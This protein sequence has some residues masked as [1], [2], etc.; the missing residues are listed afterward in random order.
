[1]RGYND[2]LAY[3][4]ELFA[5]KKSKIL[6]INTEKDDAQEE[7][8]LE[9]HEGAKVGGL[10]LLNTVKNVLC[11]TFVLSMICMLIYS[12]SEI[13]EVKDQ[14]STTETEI[15][16]LISE[17]T[18]LK[19]EFEKSI[20]L[21]NIEE[22]AR[23]LGMKKQESGQTSYLMVS[24]KD[25]VEVLVSEDESVFAKLKTFLFGE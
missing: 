24:D 14:I 18:R 2:N 11:A 23:A 8:V 13:S 16:T 12:R 20:S 9:A 4:F 15:D 3:D 10:K 6:E 25:K 5:P 21:T 7:K 17:E 22:E 19:M 1:M